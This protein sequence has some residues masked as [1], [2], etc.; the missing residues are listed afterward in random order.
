MWTNTNHQLNSNTNQFI[1]MNKL[2]GVLNFSDE[3][4]NTAP[5]ILDNIK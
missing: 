3:N 1:N 5:D 4:L 2:L